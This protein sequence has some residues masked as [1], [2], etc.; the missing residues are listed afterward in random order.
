MVHDDPDRS[1][2]AFT[3]VVINPVSAF[4]AIRETAKTAT[5]DMHGNCERQG[6]PH[7]CRI[8]FYFIR[9][10]ANVDLPRCR[11]QVTSHRLFTYSDPC[12][13]SPLDSAGK[14]PNRNP[15]AVE[16]S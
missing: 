9:H 12:Q 7:L 15:P 11:I 6:S 4:V 16:M 13:I 8:P 1:F 5:L 14:K 3:S 2:D 10:V